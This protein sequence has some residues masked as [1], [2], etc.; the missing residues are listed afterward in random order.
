MTRPL[1]AKDL[2]PFIRDVPDFPKPGIVFR[3][4]TPL[5]RDGRAFAHTIDQFAARYARHR[6][7][8]V[9]AIESRGLIFGAAVALRLGAGLVP[10]RKRGKLPHKT[11]QERCVLEYGEEVLEI[12]QDALRP[13][14]R[15]LLMDDVLATGGTMRAAIRLMRRLRARVVE[16]AFVIELTPLEGRR[17]LRPHPVFSLVQY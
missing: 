6:V 12:H 4:I 9:A 1:R 8:A 16:T 14:E 3:D 13:N 10:V 15:V 17:K 7:D 2:K 11:H 5:L